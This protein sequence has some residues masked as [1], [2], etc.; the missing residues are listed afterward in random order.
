[1]AYRKV[2]VTTV[3]TQVASY[4][5]K[6]VC[7]TIINYSG[8][9][10]F[11]HTNQTKITAEGFPLAV[12]ATMSLIK[13]DGD[14]PREALWGQTTTGTADLRVQESWEIEES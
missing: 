6:R 12:G 10:A 3:P 8:S 9:E 13:A 2:T 7:I 1:M 11:I 14:D 4:N 5:A